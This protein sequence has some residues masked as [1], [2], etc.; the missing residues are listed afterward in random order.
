MTPADLAL[1]AALSFE[2]K[3]DSMRQT[4]SGTWKVTFT[5]QASDVPRSLTEAMPGTRYQV[6]IVEIGDNEMPVQPVKEVSPAPARQLEPEPAGARAKPKRDWR[7][8]LPSNQAGMRYSK[9]EFSAFLRETR[10]DDWH[11]AMTDPK[12]CIY[13]IC[14]ITSLSQL[15]LDRQASVEWHKLDEQFLTWKAMERAS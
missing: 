3:K 7:D 9:P 1:D 13:L 6:V 8:I 12:E 10:P 2:A 15:D 4:Q 11:E 14:K 5:V